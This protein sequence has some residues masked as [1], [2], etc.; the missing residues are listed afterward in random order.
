MK[1]S[2]EDSKRIPPDR[3][4]VIFEV[5]KI[6]DG[7]TVSDFN[8]QMSS[9][10]RETVEMSTRKEKVCILLIAAETKLCLYSFHQVY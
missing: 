5:T 9:C 10:E 8:I 3:Q 6:D 4:R 2:V 7:Q 1:G